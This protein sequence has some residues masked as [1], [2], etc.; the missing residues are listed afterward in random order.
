MSDIKVESKTGL[1]ISMDLDT[2][3]AGIDERMATFIDE[4]FVKVESAVA[5]LAKTGM[6]KAAIKEKL[7]A[8]ATAG[9][10]IFSGVKR[11]IGDIAATGTNKANQAAYNTEMVTDAEEIYAWVLDPGVK[12][13]C[14][15]CLNNAEI[16]PQPFIEW[17]AIG[18]PGAGATDCGEH[19]QCSLVP[20][21][22][23]KKVSDLTGE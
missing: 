10:G 15:T 8:D 1:F 18:V 2:V 9:T 23:L 17:E 19:C 16:P 20:L 11:G 22:I 12:E 14:A 6:S 21:E 5:N 7:Y 13:H 4:I 3:I